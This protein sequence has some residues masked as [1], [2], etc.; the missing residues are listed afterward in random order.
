LAAGEADRSLPYG[1]KLEEA[2]IQRPVH[3]NQFAEYAMQAAGKP[4]NLRGVPVFTCPF[5]RYV[6]FRHDTKAYFPEVGRQQRCDVP[7][8]FLPDLSWPSH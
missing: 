3:A 4:I 8:A 6:R 1:A 7:T 5:M 2:I